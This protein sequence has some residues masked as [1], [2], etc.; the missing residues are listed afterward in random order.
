MDVQRLWLVVFR[1]SVFGQAEFDTN[2]GDH[3]VANLA[4]DA[5]PHPWYRMKTWTLPLLDL[6]LFER[7]P[8]QK[9]AVRAGPDPTNPWFQKHKNCKANICVPLHDPYRFTRWTPSGLDPSGLT[10]LVDSTDPLELRFP[11][12]MGTHFVTLSVTGAPD[13]AGP[14][15][16]TI[17]G[18]AL[19]FSKGQWTGKMRVFRAQPTFNVTIQRS[20]K[21]RNAPLIL[22][23]TR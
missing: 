21:V 20:P 22:E 8:D 23:L 11:T 16:L 4:R 18:A 3:V 10:A 12:P 5:F 17:K 14:D 9:N 6:I 2:I 15:D 7:N 19:T 1:E 13:D